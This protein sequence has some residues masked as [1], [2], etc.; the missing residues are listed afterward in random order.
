M[1]VSVLFSLQLWQDIDKFLS[2][3][4]SQGHEQHGEALQASLG[5]DVTTTTTASQGTVPVSQSSAASSVQAPS[6]NMQHQQ[7]AHNPNTVPSSGLQTSFHRPHSREDY[8]NMEYHM[9]RSSVTGDSVG[10]HCAKWRAPV[11][12]D[13][14]ITNRS[15][16]AGRPAVTSTSYMSDIQP[17][18]VRL[19][20]IK[21]EPDSEGHRQQFQQSHATGYNHSNVYGGE[22]MYAAGNSG[23]VFSPEMPMQ[24][25][26]VPPFILTGHVSPS[27]RQQT[28]PVQHQ[29][30]LQ[31]H[32]GQSA[33]AGHQ[34]Y[35]TSLY[36]STSMMPSSS[37][38]SPLH[39][40]FPVPSEPVLPRRRGRRT[41]ARKRVTVH[42]CTYTG[43]TKTY[44][45]SSHLK[46]HMRTHTG[47]KPYECNWKGCGWKFARS[48]ELTR[49]Y[50]KH[51]GDRPFQ[52]QLCERAFSRSDHLALH[53]KRHV[54]V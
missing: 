51:T 26:M 13:E 18:Y 19:P 22:T 37:V 50:R 28:Q 27:P 20:D 5:I 24:S 9:S 7:M 40:T 34:P 47:E 44:T 54:T 36:P 43:C 25:E 33:M 52:C 23:S 48:D 49:H 4:T 16:C 10:G 8:L 31:Q 53:M 30:H 29:Q 45:K 1:V 17:P 14:H 15:C 32:P 42:T 3:P 38:S 11:V 12:K 39:H 2:T 35:P 41:W 6:D 46:A 21:L